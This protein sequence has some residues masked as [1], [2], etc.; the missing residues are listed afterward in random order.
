MDTKYSELVGSAIE[1]LKY[2]Y[3][4]PEGRTVYSSAVLS[5]TGKVYSASAYGSDT[6]SLTLHGEQAA[7]AHAAAHMDGDIVA[8]ATVSDAEPED[9][10][11]CTPCGMC[12]QLIWENSLRS[13]IHIDVIMANKSGKYAVRKIDDLVPFPWP[14]RKN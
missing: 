14:P 2:A 1:A 12:K 9:G 4:I 6:A 8:I 5:R 11:F 10:V 13:G 7:L 3:G